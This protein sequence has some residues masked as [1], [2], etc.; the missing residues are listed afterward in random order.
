[1]REGSKASTVTAWAQQLN[2]MHNH[3]HTHAKVEDCICSETYRHSY[4]ENYMHA[5]IVHANMSIFNQKNEVRSFVPV[6][7]DGTRAKSKLNS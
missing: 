3:R 5:N 1:V 6:N 7:K 2:Q 4:L